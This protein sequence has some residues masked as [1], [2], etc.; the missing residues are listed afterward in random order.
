MTGAELTLVAVSAQGAFFVS[1]P[2]RLF[3]PLAAA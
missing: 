2:G 3:R 1:P